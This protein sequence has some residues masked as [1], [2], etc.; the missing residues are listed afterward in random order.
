[1]EDLIT[2]PCDELMA[3]GG[4][5]VHDRYLKETVSFSDYGEL[6]PLVIAFLR[7]I[8]KGVG[9]T[10]STGEYRARLI[11]TAALTDTL[12]NIAADVQHHLSL[13]A[14]DA[15]PVMAACES[16][17]RVQRTEVRYW[18]SR[19]EQELLAMRP[20]LV[21]LERVYWDSCF[22][23]RRATDRPTEP[24][25]RRVSPVEHSDVLAK[26]DSVITG[27]ALRMITL[28]E[29]QPATL[30]EPGGRIPAVAVDY[31]SSDAFERLVSALLERDGFAVHQATG[32]SGDNAA[33]GIAT[34]PMKQKF[35]VQAKHTKVGRNVGPEIVREVAGA[36]FRIHRADVAVVVTNGGFTRAAQDNAERSRV[37]LVDR[38]RLIRWAEHGDPL[39]DVLSG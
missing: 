22:E 24:V 1:M 4:C 31:L 20:P 39:V 13:V 29:K 17:L 26:M 21:E 15:T 3:L 38:Y 36:A 8:G 30:F 12:L 27:V 5:G 25:G 33:D 19:E 7:R 34:G 10:R 32:R 14:K 6:F 28:L 18:L 9:W 23:W 37:H 2:K 35:V 16:Y 11:D